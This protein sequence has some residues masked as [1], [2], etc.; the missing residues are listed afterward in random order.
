MNWN[1]GMYVNSV[2]IIPLEEMDLQKG[3]LWVE[4]KEGCMENVEFDEM[5]HL[6]LTEIYRGSGTDIENPKE[7]IYWFSTPLGL[8]DLWGKD[9]G[10]LWRTWNCKA[11]AETC[12]NEPWA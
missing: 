7:H 5:F 8:I 4:L 9:Y 6:T 3:F 1:K 10:K 2:S 11:D 12:K